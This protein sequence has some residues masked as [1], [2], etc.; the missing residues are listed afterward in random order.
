MKFFLAILALGVSAVSAQDACQAVAMAIPACGRTCIESAAG[1][2]GCADKDFK[3]YCQ[4]SDAYSA[5]AAACVSTAC[6]APSIA[7]V[8]SGAKS[9]C[10]CVTGAPKAAFAVPT[11]AL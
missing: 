9:A 4:K 6:P 7:V 5:K 3:C 10:A 2:V 11:P 8:D 1:A